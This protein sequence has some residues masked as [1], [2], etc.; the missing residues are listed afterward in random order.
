[1]KALKEGRQPVPGAP[2]EDLNTSTI[3]AGASSISISHYEDKPVYNNVI[4]VPTSPPPPYSSLYSSDIPSNPITSTTSVPAHYDIP[5]AP[6][7]LPLVMPLPPFAE[8]QPVVP[9]ATNVFPS[10][11]KTTSAVSSLPTRGSMSTSNKVNE[12]GK[13][14]AMELCSFAIAALKVCSFAIAANDYTFFILDFLLNF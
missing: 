3:Q 6:T 4:N 1:M 11:S 8:K 12:K 2:G 5:A 14:D 7:D 10:I 13:E 9:P